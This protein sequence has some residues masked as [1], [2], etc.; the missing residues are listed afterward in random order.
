MRLS[1]YGLPNM[2]SQ[3]KGDLFV[4]IRIYLPK[5]LNDKQKLLIKQL[6]KAGL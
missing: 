3:E 5:N 6:A 4:I 2:R 1:G